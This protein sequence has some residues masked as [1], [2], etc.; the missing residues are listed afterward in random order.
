MNW[1]YMPEVEVSRCGGVEGALRRLK[2]LN[3]S[4]RITQDQR[5]SFHTPPS[6]KRAQA[7]KAAEKRASKRKEKELLYKKTCQ[8]SYKITMARQNKAQSRG[9]TVKPANSTDKPTE[10]SNAKETA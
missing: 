1:N 10:T 7:A 5:E 8:L 6:Q 4:N 9:I 2:R 3:E